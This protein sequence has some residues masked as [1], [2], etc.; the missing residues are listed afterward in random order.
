MRLYIQYLNLFFM[1]PI[2]LGPA[3]T[4]SEDFI[5]MMFFFLGRKL[6]EAKVEFPPIVSEFQETAMTKIN[7]QRNHFIHENIINM[8]KT[9]Y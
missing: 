4:E 2:E 3:D 9:S 7:I 6:N 1:L 5:D 8:M